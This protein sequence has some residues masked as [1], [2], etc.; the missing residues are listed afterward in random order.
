MDRVSSLCTVAAWKNSPAVRYTMR[1]KALAT[2]HY[3]SPISRR[4]MIDEVH[5]RVVNTLGL[6]PDVQ[7]HNLNHGS[8][9]AVL[10]CYISISLPISAC[11]LPVTLCITTISCRAELAWVHARSLSQVAPDNFASPSVSPVSFAFIGCPFSSGF[12][13]DFVKDCLKSA[14]MSSICSV[15]TEIRMRSSVTPLLMRSSSESCSCV[16]V[17]G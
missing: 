17:Q 12:V 13:A 7:E 5:D 14:I 6:G 4:P 11:D 3:T 9:S 2:M 1:D 8:W 15:P 16:V 10:S